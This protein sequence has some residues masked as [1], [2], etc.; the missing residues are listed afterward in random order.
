MP[1]SAAA[2][3]AAVTPGQIRTGTPAARHASISSVARAKIAGSPP[4]RRTTH[5]P[6]SAASTIILSIEP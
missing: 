6:A 2:A 5:S 4:L 3:L 1:R